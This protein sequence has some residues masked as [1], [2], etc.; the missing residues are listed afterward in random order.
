MDYR[1]GAVGKVLFARFDHGEAV[2]P[3]LAEICRKEGILSGWFLLFGAM[4]KGSMVTGPS[5]ACLPPVPVWVNFPHP[6]EIVGMGSVAEKDGAPSIHL[7]ASLGR[8]R[9]VLTGCIRK[10]EEVFLVVEAMILQVT[11]LS[12]FRKLDAQT[13]LELLSFD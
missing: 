3:S 10:E 6:H 1:S 2:L 4:A 12:A 13:G 9:E 7:H 5:D 11:G 8:G